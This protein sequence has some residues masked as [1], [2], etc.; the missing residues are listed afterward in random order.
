MIATKVLGN[1]R[2]Y[3][4][5]KAIVAIPFEWF[6]LDKRRILKTAND[7][8]E[9][10]IQVDAPL[11]NGDILSDE[12]KIYAVQVKPT[13]LVCISTS[14]MEE[15]G[16]LGFELGNRHLSLQIKENLVKVPYDE[17]TYTYLKHLGFH[18]EIVEDLFTDYI[19]SKAH[20]ASSSHEHHHSH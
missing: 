14:T 18:V 1:L 12:E 15:M 9:I 17:P 8:T 13:K 7:G 19:V 3:S 16:R 4:H 10:G 5:S 2:D 11:N 20:G 6:E